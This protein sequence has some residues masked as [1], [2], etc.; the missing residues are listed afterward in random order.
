M[1]ATYPAS[2]RSTRHEGFQLRAFVSLLLVVSGVVV[3]GSGVLLLFAPSGQMAWATGW[4]A[5]GIGRQGW[6]GLH[7]VFGLLWIPLLGTHLVLNRRAILCYLKD[8]VRKTY[9]M[10]RE[11]VA[12]VTFTLVLALLTL[13]RVWPLATLVALGHQGPGR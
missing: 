2:A 10:R 7:D 1:R 8:R 4:S 13:S 6:V 5:L 11:A 9:G 12:A 3:V